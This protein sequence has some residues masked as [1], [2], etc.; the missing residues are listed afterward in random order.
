MKEERVYEHRIGE[1]LSLFV[2]NNYISNTTVCFSFLV[3][4]HWFSCTLKFSGTFLNR[5]GFF[6]LK[7]C[8]NFKHVG[9]K[10]FK[11]DNFENKIYL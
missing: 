5:V 6:F 2:V 9:K 3:W 1:V 7:T 4:W 10:C 8:E 11:N